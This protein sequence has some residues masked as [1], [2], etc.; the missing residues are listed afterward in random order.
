[1]RGLGV[2]GASIDGHKQY[3]VGAVDGVEGS[4]NVDER[5]SHTLTEAKRRGLN[6]LV[7]LSGEL[8][9]VVFESIET[10]DE[11]S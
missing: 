10:S 1:M 7:E 3:L 5:V 6:H 8:D 2:V 9:E 11:G 4:L